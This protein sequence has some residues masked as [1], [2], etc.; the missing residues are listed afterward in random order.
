MRKQFLIPALAGMLALGAADAFAQSATVVTRSG[1]RF[2]ADIMDMGRDFAFNVNGQPRRLPLGDVVLIDFAGDGRNIPNDEISKANAANGFVVMRNGEQF[3]ARLQDLMGK[4]LVALFSDG[5]KSNLGDVSRI[6]FGSVSDVPGFPNSNAAL[7]P[8]DNPGAAR[9]RER[10]EA[11]LGAPPDARSVVVPSNVE[12]TNTGI[13]VSGGQRLRFETSGEVRLSFNGQDTAQAGGGGT[14]RHAEKAP[15]AA[16]PVGALIGRIGNGQAF[17]IGA[18]NEAI[19]MTA[20]GRLFLGVND[21]HVADNSGN[22]VVKV[23]EP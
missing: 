10:R 1:E 20:N 19:D 17:A 22:F 18:A 9:R 8:G 2:R 15:I 6:Y 12:W 13:N 7:Q 11:R 23:W 16:I 5:R 3:N 14:A 21:D 4:P